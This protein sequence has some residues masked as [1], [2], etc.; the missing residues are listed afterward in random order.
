MLHSENHVTGANCGVKVKTGNGLCEQVGG[1]SWQFLAS[2]VREAQGGNRGD[3]HL[4]QG[5]KLFQRQEV[6]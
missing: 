2:I 6:G 5:A 1:S 3:L 4:Q